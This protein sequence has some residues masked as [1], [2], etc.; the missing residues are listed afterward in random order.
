MLENY[1]GATDTKGGTI[2]VD[3]TADGSGGGTSST[4]QLKASTIDDGTGSLG[5]L[6]NDGLLET[7]SGSSNLIENFSAAGSF[8]NDGKLLVTSSGTVLTLTN[9]VLENYNG[10]TDTK[11]G[12]IQVDGTADGSGGGTSSTLQ[13]KASTIDDGAGSL[14][15]LNNDGLLETTSGS[16]NLIE[17]FSATGSFTNDGKLLVTNSGTVLTLTNDVLENYNGAVDTKGGTIQV[18]GTADGSGGGTSSTLQLKASTIDDGTG[19]LGKLNN[20][21]LLETTSGSSNLIE[22]FSAA[23][24]FTNDGKLLVT[25]SGTVLTLTNDVLENTT[26]PSTPR[27]ARSRLTAR[28]TAAAAAPA[29]R[30]SSRP[31]RSTTAPAASAS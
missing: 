22:N 27:A 10:A 29:R 17:N 19:S 16:S 6:N 26:A 3:G 7:T 28:R 8:T 9:D 30:C 18:D 14:G 12:T 24:S 20:D 2:Q 31:A 13:L 11:G 15:K 1:N 4:L 23:G 21:G 5:K 25:N